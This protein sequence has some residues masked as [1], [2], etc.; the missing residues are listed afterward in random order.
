M[1]DQLR[2]VRHVFGLKERVLL[3][4]ILTIDQIWFIITKP[5]ITTIFKGNE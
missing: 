1:I 5:L 4:D 2:Q 3:V